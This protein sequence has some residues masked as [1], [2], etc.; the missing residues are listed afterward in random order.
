M[1]ILRQIYGLFK[2][3]LF[4]LTN[5]KID[6]N[7]YKEE[8]NIVSHT[9][10]QWLNRMSKHTDKILN[11]NYLSLN[12]TKIKILDFACGSGYITKKLLEQFDKI[13]LHNVEINGVDISK[14]MLPENIFDKRVKFV[15][16]DGIEFLERSEES[17]YD[18]IYIGWALPYFNHNKL[19]KLF[20]RVLRNNGIVGIIANIKGTLKDIETIFIETMLEKPDE[21]QKIMDIR[22]NLPD[23]KKKIIKWFKKYDFNPI[24]IDEGEEIVCFQSPEELYKWLKNSGALAGTNNIFKN[25]EKIEKII[26]E[27]IKK[28]KNFNNK[29]I[30]NHKFSYGIFKKEV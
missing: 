3:L 30:I 28:K 5:R 16:C 14:N 4:F 17:I 7:D 27:K 26:I 8:Y 15:E 10:S 24:E 1:K 25:S 12:A 18:A 29:Y 19:L 9:Y 11:I 6:E 21:F 13:G 2:M 20:K 22:F 23:G